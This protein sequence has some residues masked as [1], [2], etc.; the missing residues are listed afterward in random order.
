MEKKYV[1]G[2]LAVAAAATLA[3]SIGM[4]AEATTQ[5]YTNSDESIYGYT[6]DGV[7]QESFPPLQGEYSIKQIGSYYYCISSITGAYKT[8]FFTYGNGIYFADEAGRL[9][10]KGLKAIYDPTTG[11]THTYYF[12]DNHTAA[13]GFLRVDERLYYF[14]EM[15]QMQFGHFQTFKGWC[16][17]RENGK[18][19]CNDSIKVPNG[20]YL[21][22]DSDGIQ[23]N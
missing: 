20:G 15:G 22:F 10:E 5:I 11:V 17:A 16:Y 7:R 12:N 8:G 3:C 2:C 18:L 6:D 1:N 14:N 19:V 4:T 21:V 13:T 9:A 23:I